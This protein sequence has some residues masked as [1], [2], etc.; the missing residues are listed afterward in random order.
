MSDKTATKA[1]EIFCNNVIYVEGR[2]CGLQGEKHL[3]CQT[4][5]KYC[6]RVLLRAT[7]VAVVMC[8]SILNIYCARLYENTATVC[9]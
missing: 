4:V 9:C 8:K 2:R 5:C 7:V 3:L 1:Q 6:Y